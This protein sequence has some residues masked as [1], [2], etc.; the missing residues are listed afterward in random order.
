MPPK[1]NKAFG[2][3]VFCDHLP[4]WLI[5]VCVVGFMTFDIYSQ[6]NGINMYATEPQ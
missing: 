3:H 6:I 4:F 2:N 5:M 1:M